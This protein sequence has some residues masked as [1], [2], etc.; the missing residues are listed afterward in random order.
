MRRRMGEGT[1]EWA[2][3]QVGLGTAPVPLQSSCAPAHHLSAGSGRATRA[4]IAE[5]A[6]TAETGWEGEA[7][8]RASREPVKGSVFIYL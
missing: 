7:P 4:W 2:G 6:E 3:P 5:T 8:D 1:S